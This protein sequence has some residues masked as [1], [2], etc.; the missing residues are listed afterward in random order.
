MLLSVARLLGLVMLLS[1]GSLRAATTA[2]PYLWR[3]VVIEGGGFVSGLEFHPKEPGLLYA[4]TDV[5]GA[6]RWDEM[7]DKWIPLNDGL[8]PADA[9]LTGVLS[10]A[11]DPNDP[12]QLYLA[13][14]Q[15]LGP[16]ARTAAILRSRDR[17]A[18]WE[19]TELPIKLGGNQ[20]GRS[21]GERLRVDPRDGKILLLGTTRDGLWRSA[22]GGVSW[23]V[24]EG[25]PAKA[26]TFVHFLSDETT[27]S[28]RTRDLLV[29][30]AG[31]ATNLWRSEDCGESWRPVAGGG[32]GLIPRH[33]AEA[34]DGYLYFVFTDALGPNGISRGEIVS[35]NRHSDEW[36]EITPPQ[37]E[38]GWGGIT[39]DAGH[40]GVVM[41]ST[42]D[43]WH[44]RDEIYRSTD[45]GESWSPILI[46]GTVESASA[47]YTEASTPHW[48][49]DLALDPHDG[50]R[51]WFVT[52]Y[53]V[54]RSTDARAVDTGGTST[55]RFTSAGLEETVPLEIISPPIGCHL[56]SAIGD[57]D[58]FRH[59]DFSVSPPARHQP[60]RGTSLSIEFAARRPD[61][62]VRTHRI[63][64]GFGQYSVDGGRQWAD[65][66]TAPADVAQ[67]KE[68]PIRL[69]ADGDRILWAPRH[70]VPAWSDDRG[71][72]WRTCEGLPTGTY[73]I[74]A[75]GVDAA[76]V[77]AWES[78]Q[79]LLFR[80][81]D[82]G[83]SFEK[84][85]YGM[86]RGTLA[87]APGRK[88]EVW[89]G[90]GRGLQVS[91]DGGEHWA[92]RHPSL[93]AWLLGFGA[94]RK[95]DDPPAVF[96]WGKLDGLAGF[97]RS[98][99]EGRNWIRISDPNHLFGSCNDLTGDP[100]VYGRI[101]L[102]TGGRGIIYGEIAG[103]P[104]APVIRSAEVDGEK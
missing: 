18:S 66:A 97:F 47:P 16:H 83:S 95:E 69:T 79:G 44:P 71:D 76:I 59:E 7:A 29:G 39:V 22:D 86:G 96:A 67:G 14:G 55:F 68:G 57:I 99:D 13:C 35:W 87:V 45:R 81:D 54:F 11:M 62:M 38:G 94:G 51:L 24:M 53:G 104:P 102:A 49:G 75:D 28:E 65:F 40:P 90:T 80:S 23:K 63:A 91:R 48:I 43:R 82:G 37:G 92:M 9:Q 74:A 17:G 60:M 10:L 36:K 2:Q 85:V 98:D 6:F 32:E 89:L 4:R 93:E 73:E 5:G 34:A 88:G 27:T 21:A 78:S 70:A 1:V 19:R 72:S 103:T 12:E 100:R 77:F 15:Y 84:V 101:Y 42:L 30:T 58:G 25:F 31:E 52:G 50:N 8:G 20:D 3:N 41:V 56:V 61:V 33:V 64:P 26:V 46:P